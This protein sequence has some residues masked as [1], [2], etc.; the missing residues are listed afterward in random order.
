MAAFGTSMTLRSEG[1]AK[2]P[3]MSPSA[4]NR[5]ARGGTL[6]R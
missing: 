6:R 1:A 4:L 5:R 2:P 3:P